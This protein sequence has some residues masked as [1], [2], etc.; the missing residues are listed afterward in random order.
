MKIGFGVMNTLRLVSKPIILKRLLQAAKA[1]LLW[2]VV[3]TL[4]VE[5]QRLL[6]IIP[7]PRGVKQLL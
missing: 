1:Q 3:P 2:D 6:V 7:M 5:T 4:R